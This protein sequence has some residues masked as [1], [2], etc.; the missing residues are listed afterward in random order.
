M[1]DSDWNDYTALIRERVL[2]AWPGATLA[3][4]AITPGTPPS[5]T[6]EVEDGTHDDIAVSDALPG[7]IDQAT[8]DFESGTRAGT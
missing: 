5:Y 7:L 3:F 4:Y 8:S 6:V 2:A 1:S